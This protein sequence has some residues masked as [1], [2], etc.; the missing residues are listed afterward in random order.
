MWKRVM[1]VMETFARCY[2]G[3]EGIF[4]RTYVNVI[5]PHTPHVGDTVNEPCRVKNGTVPKQGADE[6]RYEYR[7][8]PEV[9]RH[10]GG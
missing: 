5:R 10:S 9:H 4:R 7:L 2:H 3:N 8:S 1:V 6:V